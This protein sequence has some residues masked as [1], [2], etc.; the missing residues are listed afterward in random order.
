MGWGVNQN[1][2]VSF[3]LFFRQHVC[4]S[5]GTQKWKGK[6]NLF[7][8]YVRATYGKI[9][10]T[11]SIVIPEWIYLVLCASQ[12]Q[13]QPAFETEYSLEHVCLNDGLVGHVID[14]C[15]RLPHATV[16]SQLLSSPQMINRRSSAFRLSS[17]PLRIAPHFIFFFPTKRALTTTNT[18]SQSFI[19]SRSNKTWGS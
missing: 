18:H 4:G 16:I 11:P 2:H 13:S 15:D 3:Q 8:H 10:R 17:T 5:R 19:Y 7:L 12:I 14:S 6:K 9:S 1:Q